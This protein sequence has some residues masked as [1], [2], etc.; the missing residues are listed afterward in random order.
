ME[1]L[2]EEI[3]SEIGSNK[4]VDLDRD[5]ENIMGEQDKKLRST[6]KNELWEGNSKHTRRRTF[7]WLRLGHIMR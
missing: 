6:E 5:G 1:L 3:G 2:L 4:D 7:H